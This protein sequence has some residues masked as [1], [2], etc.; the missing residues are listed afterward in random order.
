MQFLNYLSLNPL[1]ILT[2]KIAQRT[3]TVKTLYC[4]THNHLNLNKSRTSCPRPSGAI[5]ARVGMFEKSIS[6]NHERI[7]LSGESNAQ[8]TLFLYFC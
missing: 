4:R 5:N 3:S 6:W 1:R 2:L 7:I 8:K